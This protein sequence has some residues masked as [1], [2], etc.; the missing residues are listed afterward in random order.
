MSEGLI[1]ARAG[2]TRRPNRKYFFRGL[3]PARAGTTIFRPSAILG[4]R[5]HPRSRGDHVDNLPLIVVM[6]GSSPLARGPQ[7]K[8]G[9]A[10]SLIGLIPARAG[11][12]LVRWVNRWPP[13]A[14]PRSRG[15]HAGRREYEQLRE[16]SSPLARGPLLHLVLEREE[17]GLIPARAGTTILQIHINPRIRAHPRSRG[18]HSTSA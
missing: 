6:P 13:R 11:T 17:G 16:G 2:T 3:I 7:A 10:Q 9:D 8:T 12:T 18:D 4:S 5:A 14:H 15:D 1:P